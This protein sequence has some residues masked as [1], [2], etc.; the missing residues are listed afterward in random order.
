MAL[1]ARRRLFVSEYLVLLSASK[2]AVRAGYQPKMGSLLLK[3]PEVHALVERGLERRQR[4]LEISAEKVIG[5]LGAL[6]FSDPR[7]LFRDD[8]SMLPP[9]DWPDEVASAV[10]SIEVNELFDWQDNGAG[11]EK[12][13]VGFTKKLKLW[14][15]PA[16]LQMLGKHFQLWQDQAERRVD[17]MSEDERVLRAATLIAA[18]LARLKAKEAL[19]ALPASEATVEAAHGDE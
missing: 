4:M 1:D 12:V 6:A 11:R 14:D 7:K 10:S 18:G 3:E 8:G 9:S 17:E 13:Q 5:E 19:G 2:A 16:A 15:K